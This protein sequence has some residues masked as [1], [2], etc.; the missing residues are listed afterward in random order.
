MISI[1]QDPDGYVWFVAKNRYGKSDVS[2]KPLPHELECGRV[3]EIVEIVVADPMV[4][5][6]RAAAALGGKD[7]VVEFVKGTD[8]K[9]FAVGKPKRVKL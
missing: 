4:D 6:A 8:L 1:N 5:A 9:A 2:T 3:V 7:A